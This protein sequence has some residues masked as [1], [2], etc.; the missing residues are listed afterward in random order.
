MSALSKFVDDFTMH[1]KL[2]YYYHSITFLISLP[3]LPRPPLLYKS[4]LHVNVHFGV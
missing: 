4:L 3:H 2:A 1:I